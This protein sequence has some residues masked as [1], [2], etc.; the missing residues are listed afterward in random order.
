MDG[1]IVII[2]EMYGAN[3]AADGAGASLWAVLLSRD[4]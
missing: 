4:E 2:I 3:V 1:W